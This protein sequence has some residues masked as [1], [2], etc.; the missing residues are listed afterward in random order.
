MRPRGE[1]PHSLAQGNLDD[2][3]DDWLAIE[4][5]MVES[6]GFRVVVAEA[7]LHQARHLAGEA[8]GISVNPTGTAGLAGPP[9]L[10]EHGAVGPDE[11]AAVV[12]TGAER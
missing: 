5:A 6:D 12:F 11:S 1:S 8:N 7:R 3:T 4:R 9:Q 2:E 10:R